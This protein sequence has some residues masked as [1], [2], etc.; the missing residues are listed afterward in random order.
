MGRQKKGL[1]IPKDVSRMADILL[2]F[3]D[4][5]AAGFL[6]LCGKCSWPDLEELN[7]MLRYVNGGADSTGVRVQ[8]GPSIPFAQRRVE[9]IES[10]EWV[11]K[12]IDRYGGT[13]AIATAMREY[14]QARPQDCELLRRI[15]MAGMPGAK[16][17]EA[18]AEEFFMDTKTLYA[19]KRQAVIDIAFGVVY[20]GED[21]D[22]AG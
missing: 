1:W 6:V 7:E 2:L 10:A 18:L 20:S 13:A 5:H 15:G 14:K 3:L 8:G 22:L 19:R 16:S 11:Y 9:S 4:K 12:F 17:L 21:F